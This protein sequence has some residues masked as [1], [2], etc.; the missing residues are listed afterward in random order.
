MVTSND[1]NELDVL[2]PGHF[3]IDRPIMAMPDRDLENIPL[4]RLD[5][6]QLV[7]QTQQSFWK[8]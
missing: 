4:N 3:L 5:R 1:P 6:W 2:N 7:K 8:R